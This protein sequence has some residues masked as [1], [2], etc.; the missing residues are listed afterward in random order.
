[1]DDLASLANAVENIL[2][3]NITVGFGNDHV[4][5]TI[6][7]NI[8][9]GLRILLKSK[10]LAGLSDILT[11]TCEAYK[12]RGPLENSYGDIGI[13]L[14]I[15]YADNNSLSGVGFLEAKKR[16][17]QKGDYTAFNIAQADRIYTN[18]PNSY[19]LLYDYNPVQAEC[20]NVNIPYR[21]FC[22][23]CYRSLNENTHAVVVPMNLVLTRESVGKETYRFA[24]PFSYQ[25]CFRYLLGFDL[26]FVSHPSVS[27][28]EYMIEHRTKHI[29]EIT[30]IHGDRRV[31]TSPTVNNNIYEPLE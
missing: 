24:L 25:L 4:E 3:K 5:D 28:R 13:I 22:S 19:L 12:Y 29:M 10:Q 15:Y 21:Q 26:N 11:I 31:D 2:S 9:T 7:E 17:K 30:V 1:M 16:D 8:L 6:T 14:N 23:V 20:S 18:A 27:L